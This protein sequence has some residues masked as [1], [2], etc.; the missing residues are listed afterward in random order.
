MERGTK[1]HKFQLIFLIFSASEFDLPARLDDDV[2]EHQQWL[3]S[4]VV[5]K[6]DRYLAHILF[7]SSLRRSSTSHVYG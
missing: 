7:V 1:I 2:R 4:N 3:A 5:H 6:D